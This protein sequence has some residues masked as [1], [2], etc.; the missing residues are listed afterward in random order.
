MVDFLDYYKDQ[1]AFEAQVEADATSFKPSG[2]MIYS[3]TRQSPILTGK[4]KGTTD[5]LHSESDNAVVFEAYHVSLFAIYILFTHSRREHCQ[6]ESSRRLGV[7]LGLK[8]TTNECNYSFCCTLKLDHTLMMK[9]NH[10]SSLYCTWLDH[11]Y[12]SLIFRIPSSDTLH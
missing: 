5:S 12:V 2:Q 9:R 7:H 4:G 3:Y 6:T 8:N 10:G 1:T 11:L